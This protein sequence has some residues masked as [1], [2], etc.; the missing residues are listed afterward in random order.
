MAV[1]GSVHKDEYQCNMFVT[2]NGLMC[3]EVVESALFDE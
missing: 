3:I 1:T 2:G